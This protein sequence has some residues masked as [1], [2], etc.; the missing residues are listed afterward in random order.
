MSLPIWSCSVWGLPCRP[1]YAVRGALLPHPFT[2][3][4]QQLALLN[5]AVCFLLHWP[6]CRL[7]AAV[8]DV[9]RHTALRSSDFPPP[10]DRLRDRRQRSSGRLQHQSNAPRSGVDKLWRR[11]GADVVDAWSVATAQEQQ[12]IAPLARR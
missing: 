6:S 12:Q 1:A 3:T 5:V 4:F 11:R 9:I 10:P 7:W 2:L 8:P